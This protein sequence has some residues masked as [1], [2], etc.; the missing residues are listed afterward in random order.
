LCLVLQVADGAITATASQQ[1]G[2]RHTG[3]PCCIAGFVYGSV[4]RLHVV[5]APADTGSSTRILEG[6]MEVQRLPVWY[7]T[8]HATRV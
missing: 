1:N 5:A 2:L 4:C 6:W 3:V 8:S 7:E